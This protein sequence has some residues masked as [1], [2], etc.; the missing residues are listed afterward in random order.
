ASTLPVDPLLIIE[1]AEALLPDAYTTGRIVPL[2][3][4]EPA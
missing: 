3:Y 2:R 1:R 4:A